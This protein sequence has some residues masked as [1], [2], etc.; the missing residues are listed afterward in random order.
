MSDKPEDQNQIDE[1]EKALRSAQ[2]IRRKSVRQKVQKELYKK[3]WEQRQEMLRKRIEIA[4]EGLTAYEAKNYAVA[5]NKFVTYLHALEEIR[6]VPSNGLNPQIFDVKKDAAELMLINSVYWHL[7]VIYDKVPDSKETFQ[8]ALAQYVRFTVG[9]TFQP[10]AGETLRRFLRTSTI[11]HRADFLAAYKRIGSDKCFVATAVIDL[12]NDETMTDL[13]KF[14]DQRLSQSRIGRGMIAIYYQVGPHIA[15]AVICLP[16]AF[17][18]KIAG[19]IQS[20][21]DRVR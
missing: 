11:V 8:T 20:L 14:R 4:K 13:R 7:A 9:M 19:A 10:L 2:Q 18:R 5:V 17:R 15:D 12:L 16:I 21:A 3:E 1:L 6:K